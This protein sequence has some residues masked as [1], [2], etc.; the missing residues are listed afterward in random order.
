[1]IHNSSQSVLSYHLS[2]DNTLKEYTAQIT[3]SS[4][5]SEFVQSYFNSEILILLKR[6]DY[7]LYS[8]QILVYNSRNQNL[9]WESTYKKAMVFTTFKDSDDKY[10]IY[11]A[12]NY[13]DGSSNE[14]LHQ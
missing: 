6:K 13:N 14:I 11:M 5:S 3:D 12:S 8:D 9:I 2:N 10:T 7:I 1:M 4:R